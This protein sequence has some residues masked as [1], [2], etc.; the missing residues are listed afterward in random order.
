MYDIIY[1][2]VYYMYLFNPYIIQKN[3]IFYFID[4]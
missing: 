2:I 4:I 3:D 1:F